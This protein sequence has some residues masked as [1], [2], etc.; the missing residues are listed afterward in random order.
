[1]APTC[2]TCDQP[3]QYVIDGADPSKGNLACGPCRRGFWPL[4]TAT[5]LDSAGQ[6]TTT[7]GA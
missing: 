7:E 6:P 3:A 2:H 4:S 1:M 5:P